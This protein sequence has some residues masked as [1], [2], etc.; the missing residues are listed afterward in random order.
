[1]LAVGIDDGDDDDDDDD[2]LLFVLLVLDVTFAGPE[3]NHKHRLISDKTT[4]SHR[5]MCY[6]TDILLVITLIQ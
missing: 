2:I 6:N 1:M 3:N 4:A 5:K